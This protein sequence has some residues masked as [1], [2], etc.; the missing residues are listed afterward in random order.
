RET[1]EAILLVGRAIGAEVEAKQLVAEMQTEFHEI[2]RQAEAFSWHP[3]VYFEEWPEPFI[4]GICW[5]SELIELAGG[6]D[7]FPEFRDRKSAK[8]R[9]VS[10]QQ[11]IER[12]PQVIFASWCGKPA[13]LGDIFTR[14]GWNCIEAVQTRRVY[15][16]PSADILQPGPSLLNGL[17]RIAQTLAALG[18]NASRAKGVFNVTK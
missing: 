10:P 12:N 2:A 8:D 9:M 5:V 3:R 17:R 13:H 7:I 11:V 15:E 14:P 6:Q 16:I 4:S 18:H 1:F